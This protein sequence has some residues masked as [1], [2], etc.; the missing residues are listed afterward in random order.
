[1]FL[2]L[3]LLALTTIDTGDLKTPKRTTKFNY[4]TRVIGGQAVKRREDFPYQASVRKYHNH[5]CGGSIITAKHVLTAA[6]CCF[7][8]YDEILSPKDL[9]VVVGALDLSSK[10]YS[11]VKQVLGMKYHYGYNLYTYENDVAVLTVSTVLVV[12]TESIIL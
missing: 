11:I 9:T 2:H 10:A 12:S 8:E 4:E 6:H 7:D 5:H 3:I 1:M